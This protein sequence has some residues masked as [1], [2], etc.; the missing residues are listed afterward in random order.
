[1][2]PWH[3]LLKV[4]C[5]KD[6]LLFS[7]L[8]KKPN[9]WQNHFKEDTNL[10]QKKKNVTILFVIKQ[11]GKWF[12]LYDLK[13]NNHLVNSYQMV[14]VYEGYIYLCF[15]WFCAKESSTI[16]NLSSVCCVCGCVCFLDSNV[17]RT[18]LELCLKNKEN[19][20]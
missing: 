20:R 18:S 17:K 16:W 6:L 8:K 4:T 15:C 5:M 19:F 12:Q 3:G 1:M 10:Y 13:F 14:V 2:H 9:L 7:N 11:H